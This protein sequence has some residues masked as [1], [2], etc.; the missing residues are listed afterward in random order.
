[1]NDFVTVD[2]E[3]YAAVFVNVKTQIP[4]TITPMGVYRIIEVEGIRLQE[5]CEY[6]YSMKGMVNYTILT[7]EDREANDPHSMNT[8]ATIID[9]QKSF[10]HLIKN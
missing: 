8:M 5:L 4:I 3:E 1:M 10:R 9:Q 2:N 7:W 6:A